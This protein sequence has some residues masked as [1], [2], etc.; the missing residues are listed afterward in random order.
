LPEIEELPSLEV[1]RKEWLGLW[2]RSP[3]GTPFQSPV[4]LIPWWR[5]FGDGEP[6][7][8]AVREHGRLV[9]LAP[10]YI[11]H[12]AIGRKL[13][14]LGIGVSDYLDPLL[15]PEHGPAVLAYL[16]AQGH[17][18][19]WADLEGQRAGTALLT[20][21]L[22]RSW[23]APMQPREPCPVLALP[24]AGSEG[25]RLAARFARLAYD[26]RRVER[27]GGRFESATEASLPTMLEEL[28]DLH[29]RRWAAVGEPGVLVDPAVRA[30]HAEAAASLLAAGLLRFYALRLDDRMVAAVYG[31]ADRTRFHFYLTGFDPEAPNFSLGSL[32]IGHAIRRAI[33]EGCAEFH[34]LRGR[35]AYKYDWGAEDRAMFARRLAPS[36]GLAEVERRAVP[37]SQVGC[38]VAQ[39][40]ES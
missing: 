25:G 9:G 23:E 15:E 1:V 36:G 3:G 5:H 18:F 29:G 30:F 6:M 37:A 22:P 20:A 8:L 4:W 34:F 31:F 28:V 40:L 39:E 16:A 33:E 21:G 2:E 14:P 19:D 17:R 26:Q 35:E 27:L 10:L 24:R 11:R 32:V 7:M 12:E 13:L 38:A